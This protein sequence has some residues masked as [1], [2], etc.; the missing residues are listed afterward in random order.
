MAVRHQSG[1]FRLWLAGDFHSS[2]SPIHFP[3]DV[4]L[5]FVTIVL[6]NFIRFFAIMLRFEIFFR[7][8]DP[9]TAAYD[10]IPHRKANEIGFALN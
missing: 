9:A 3:F 6:V 2:I 7:D 4:N 5:G 1:T 10:G 8:I